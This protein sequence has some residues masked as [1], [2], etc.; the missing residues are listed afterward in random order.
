MEKINRIFADLRDK[1]EEYRRQR[2][3][4]DVAVIRSHSKSGE[5]TAN[6]PLPSLPPP[7][8]LEKLARQNGLTFDKTKLVAQWQLQA[9]EIGTSFVG[10]RDIVA[11][12]AMTLAKFHAGESRSLQGDYYLYWKTEETKDRIPE[13]TDKGERELVL[14]TWKTVNGRSLAMKAADALAADARKA[15]KPLKQVLADRPDQRVI[16]PPA[17]SWMT[18]GNVPLGSAPNAARLS[19]VA[20]VGMAG[21]DFMRAVFHLEPGQVGVALNAPQTVAYVIRLD[22]L[23]PS[24]DVLWEQFKVDDF[25]KYAAAAIGEER[26]IYQAWLNELKTSAG[27]QWKQKPEQAQDAGPQQQEEE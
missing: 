6:L 23:T 17:F 18:F 15:N 14:R 13:F 8:D 11:R 2:S 5:T 10:M 24:H 1:M 21:D 7:L 22:Q 3:A 27:L 16:M 25:S 19:S 26:Q 12:Y 4:Y 9:T 20:G